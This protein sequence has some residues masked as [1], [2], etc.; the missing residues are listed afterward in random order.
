M[1]FMVNFTI[2]GEPVPKGRPRFTR[3]GRTYTPKKTKDYES[4]VADA[5]KRAM[6]S[7]EPLETAVKAYIHVTYTVP[8]S[9]P[10]KRTEACLDG[11]EKYTKKPDLD[12]VVKAITDGMNGIVYKDDSQITHLS[13]TK[14]Y[15]TQNMVQVMIVEDII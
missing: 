7:S 3:Q 10:K 14:V 8:A 4:I 13:A 9:Y 15:G 5:A 2:E 6:G 1:T 11:S 12:N